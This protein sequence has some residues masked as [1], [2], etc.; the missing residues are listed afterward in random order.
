MPQAVEAALRW[1]GPLTVLT[2]QAMHDV[3]LDGVT[4]SAGAKIDV[5]AG[6]ANRDPARYPNPDAFDLF[7]KQERHMAFAFGPH[8]CIGQH[9]A[10][11]EM[12]R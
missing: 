5:V 1:E 4:I 6:S 2:R 3:E 12:A 7:R 9:L 11:I 10:R 8:V